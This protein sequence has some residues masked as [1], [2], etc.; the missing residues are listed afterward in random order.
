MNISQS[1][2]FNTPNHTNTEDKQDQLTNIDKIELP[3][4]SVLVFFLDQVAYAIETKYIKS[5][6][7]FTNRT[8]LHKLPIFCQGI[9]HVHRKIILLIDLKCFFGIS[10][11]NEPSPHVIILNH[12]NVGMAISSDEIKGVIEI[13]YHKIDT[14][15]LPNKID[16]QFIK[17]TGSDSI[18][19]L[20]GKHLI[21][22]LG[23]YFI[24]A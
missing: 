13:S 19:V 1:D 9:M 16:K 5:V 3:K 14:Q 17:G 22:Q 10:E 23:N 24:C 2:H 8:T 6:S 4:I 7:I 18:I 20:D 12:P 11:L 15:P 21:E